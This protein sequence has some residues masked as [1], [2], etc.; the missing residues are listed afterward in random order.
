MHTSMVAGPPA[1]LLRP[2]LPFHEPVSLRVRQE[3]VAPDERA[4]QLLLPFPS[5]PFSSQEPDRLTAALIK[6]TIWLL[7]P[8]FPLELVISP[9]PEPGKKHINALHSESFPRHEMHRAM[10]GPQNTV[11]TRPAQK[12]LSSKRFLNVLFLEEMFDLLEDILPECTQTHLQQ[13]ILKIT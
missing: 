3:P 10:S 2:R 1:D 11:H 9:P 7:A 13:D 6:Q 12:H 8:V 5:V 4:L